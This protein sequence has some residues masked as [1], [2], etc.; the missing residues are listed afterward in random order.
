MVAL[1]TTVPPPLPPPILITGDTPASAVNGALRVKTDVP[2]TARLPP[3]LNVAADPAGRVSELFVRVK[4][5]ANPPPDQVVGPDVTVVGTAST[6]PE[7]VTPP[8]PTAMDPD[9]PSV[10]LAPLSVNPFTDVAAASVTV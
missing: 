8:V 1:T 10:A 5:A 6:P 7:S 4:L 9:P 3:V 2:F